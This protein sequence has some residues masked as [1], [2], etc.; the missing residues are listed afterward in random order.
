MS[1]N[2]ILKGKSGDEIL[3]NLINLPDN[4]KVNLVKRNSELKDFLFEQNLLGEE[5]INKL[6]IYFVEEDSL[7]DVVFVLTKNICIDFFNKAL[8]IATEK[9]KNVLE[10]LELDKRYDPSFNNNYLIRWNAKIGNFKKVQELMSDKRVDPSDVKNSAFKGAKVFEHTEV[11]KLLLMDKRVRDK[12]TLHDKQKY[13]RESIG[14][15]LRPKNEDEIIK[16]AM[17]IE[18][19]DELLKAAVEKIKSKELTKIALE[20]GADPE[21]IDPKHI[22]NPDLIN[23]LL[24]N[25]KKEIKTTK[26]IYTALKLGATDAVINLINKNLLDPSKNKLKILIWAI[27]FGRKKLIELLF[28]DPRINV[29]QEQ[30]ALAEALALSIAR[31]TNSYLYVISNPKI[32]PG[33]YNNMPIKIA[34]SFGVVDAVEALLKD[35]RVDASEKDLSSGLD[36]YALISAYD[37]LVNKGSDINKN[38]LKKIIQLLLTDKKVRRKLSANDIKKYEKYGT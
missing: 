10:I 15:V 2:N 18:N 26:L 20:R 17:Q 1:I 23:I 11:I 38:N 9:N 5:A 30:D 19:P 27:G 7:D 8:V 16:S 25:T 37:N 12:L 24:N 36:N 3:Q 33:A 22:K 14:N 29:E 31:E 28:N 21:S 34:S 6:L 35:P 32:N 13:V 4:D